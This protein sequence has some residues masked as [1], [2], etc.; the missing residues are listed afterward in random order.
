MAVDLEPLHPMSLR[1]AIIPA[2]AVF[3]AIV[4]WAGRGGEDPPATRASRAASAALPMTSSGWPRVSSADSG[5]HGTSSAVPATDEDSSFGKYVTGKYHFIFDDVPAEAANKLRAALLD[6]ERVAVAINTARQSTDAALKQEIPRL[7]SEL[8]AQDRKIGT[9]LRPGDLAAFDVLRN[10]DIEQFQLDDY[11]GGVSAVAPLNDADR[12]AILYAKLVYREQFRQV[13]AQSGL[14]SGQLN[15]PERRQAFAEV[16]RALGDSR[17]H[18]LQEARQY[19]YNDQQF[20]LLSNYETTE[21]S[22]ELEKL[23]RIAYDGP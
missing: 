3:A 6:R 23:R 15:A 9:L 5:G 8:D 14:M 19:L 20:N 2:L 7:Q 4:W 10:S 17:E 11:A 13:L 21:Y 12:K 16:S 18:Y 1:G 22:A